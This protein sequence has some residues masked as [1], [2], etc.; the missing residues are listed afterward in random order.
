[1]CQLIQKDR[2]FLTSKCIPEPE[3]TLARAWPRS[4]S[5]LSI[6][7]KFTILYVE[8]NKFLINFEPGIWNA[9]VFMRSTWVLSLQCQTRHVP[10]SD[11]GGGG[12]VPQGI[13]KQKLCIPVRTQPRRDNCFHWDAHKTSKGQSVKTRAR[14]QFAGFP[15]IRTYIH[16]P[17]RQVPASEE[18]RGNVIPPPKAP[19]ARFLRKSAVKELSAHGPSVAALIGGWTAVCTVSALKRHNRAYILA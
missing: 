3:L 1:M 10:S 15:P 19:I 8:C 6:M 5:G 18:L 12:Y 4:S 13:I 17:S 16:I 7:S 2:V 11:R 9:V 14:L